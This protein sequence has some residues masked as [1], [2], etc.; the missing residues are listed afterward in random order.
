M[1]VLDRRVRWSSAPLTALIAGASLVLGACAGEPGTPAGP[2]LPSAPSVP[3]QYRSASFLLKVSPKNRTATI[4]TS[5]KSHETPTSGT[6]SLGL[7]RPSLSLLGGD[8]IELTT[9][10]FLAGALGAATPGKVRISFDV[11]ITNKLNGV[12]LITPTWPTPPVG[13]TGV[14]MFPFEYKVITTAGGVSVGGEGNTV[15]VESPR[16][17]AVSAS[18]DWAGA[19]HNFFNDVGCSLASNDCFPWESYPTIESGATSVARSIGFDVD[20]T[21]GDFEVKMIIAANL[22]NATQLFGT[23]AGTVTSP[24]RGALSGATVSIAGGFSGT[25]N[26]SGAFSVAAVNVGV[27]TVTVSNLPNGCTAPAAQSITVNAGAT[28]AANFVVTCSVLSGTVSGVVSS[29]LGGTVAGVSVLVTP[30]GATAPAPVITPTSGAYSIATVPIGTTGGGTITLSNL[31][32]SCT[33]PGP[34]P[35]SGLTNGG[36]VTLNVTLTCVAPPAFYN[37]TVVWTQTGSQLNAEFRIDMNGYN[38]P[39]INGAG[40]DNIGAF[41]AE[42]DYPLAKLTFASGGSVAG[43]VLDGVTVNGVS[44]PG[45]LIIVAIAGAGVGATGNVAIGRA[46]FNIVPGAT[47]AVA[48]TTVVTEASSIDFIDLLPKILVINGSTTLP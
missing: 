20:P 8:V 23:V 2:Q 3:P 48:T 35:Y 4:V 5:G 33:N 46:T 45:K 31:P 29:S 32:A 6:A 40:P 7:G 24:Q 37:Y 36:A 22:E 44:V 19:P 47:G 16:G 1:S 42:I 27:R 25:T 28:A 9:G 15:I 43:S 41:S 39:L 38:N 17:G 11:N 18:S 10:N 30:T 12:R 13:Q 14:F 26:A 34:L 21:V